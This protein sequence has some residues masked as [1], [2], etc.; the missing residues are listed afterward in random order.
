MEECGMSQKQ[1]RPKGHYCKIC[2]K[3]KANEKFSGRGHTTHI[4]KDCSRL[5]A[6]DKAEAIT[7]H[8]LLSFPDRRLSEREKKWLKNRIHDKRPAVAA[9]AKRVYNM[10]F[11]HAARNAIKQQLTIDT[12][13][14][15]V[16]AIVMD[17]YGDCQSVNKR[18]SANRSN[19]ILTMTD[20]DTDSNSIDQSITLEPKKMTKLLRW[21][22]HTL[23]VFTW[24][25]EFGLT[26]D[27]DFNLDDDML[28]IL[29]DEQKETDEEENAEP[30]DH[31]NWR[32]QITYSNRM[33]QDTSC[34]DEE[35]LEYQ[36]EEL[37][38]IL[39]SYFE[40]E[41]GE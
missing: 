32:I 38:L 19:H 33:K 17:E 13:V 31:P 16:H 7:I 41:E 4:C 28:P 40:S 10:H 39:Q 20:F 6:A 26:D 8:R 30:T 25:Q 29:P 22:V 2:G 27:T 37:Y 34:Y 18:F 35:Y 14:F 12:L 9:L 11:P 15:E 21:I 3:Y 23:E 5:S 1:D 36:P 24:A